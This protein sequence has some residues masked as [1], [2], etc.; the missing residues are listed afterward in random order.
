MGFSEKSQVEESD[1]RKWM[2]AGIGVR[3]PLKP[4]YTV[5]EKDDTEECSTTP[6]SEEARIP[7]TFTCPPPPKKPKPSSNFTTYHKHFF[8]PSDLETVFI[9][10]TA[11]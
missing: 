11:T 4:I 9:L 10:E 6:T 5:V 3:A 1:S 7:T 8:T 2:M